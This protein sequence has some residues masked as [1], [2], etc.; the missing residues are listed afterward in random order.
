[1]PV[2]ISAVVIGIVSSISQTGF[3]WT[4]KFLDFDLTRLDPLQ[5]VKKLWSQESLFE[6]LK[7][8][9]KFAIVGTILFSFTKSWLFQSSSLW[10]LEPG[11]TSVVLG[12]HIFKILMIVSLS[13]LI[14]SVGDYAFQKFRYERSI[15]MSKQELREERKQVEGDPQIRARIR[16]VQRQI[17]TRKMTAAV[18]KADVVV[19]NPT[20]IAVALMYDR[21]KMGA[22]RVVAKGA[23]FMAE[24]I[25]K[26]ARE[27]GVPCVENVPLARALYKAIKIGHFVSRDLYNA[28]AEVFA[29]VYRLKGRFK[30]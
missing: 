12:G 10:D 17:A 4:T 11:Q 15:R 14:L 24:K 13:M 29:Y 20:H 7:A 26:I 21:E 8:I 6:L 3:V 25:K 27:S 5:G 16:A 28:V 2:G 18:K 9:L 1:M 22:P 19:T 23:D 30:G